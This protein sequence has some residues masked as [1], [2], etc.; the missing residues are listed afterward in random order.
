MI[1][2]KTLISSSL[3]GKNKRKLSISGPPTVFSG[4]KGWVAVVVAMEP[5]VVGVVVGG[6]GT[7]TAI[8]SREG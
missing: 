2:G 5:V 4:W 3:I 1:K 8:L 7:A 6:V